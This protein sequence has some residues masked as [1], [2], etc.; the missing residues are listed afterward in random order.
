MFSARFR[1]L[2][3]S[4]PLVWMNGLRQAKFL[5]EMNNAAGYKPVVTL[6][7]DPEIPMDNSNQSDNSYG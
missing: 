3:C 6:H 2:V 1:E 7:R 4:I 5:H